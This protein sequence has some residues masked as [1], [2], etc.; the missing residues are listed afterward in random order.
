VY[1]FFVYLSLLHNT[2]NAKQNL[3]FAAQNCGRV[4]RK[5]G[6]AAGSS[7]EKMERS[8]K[9]KR[10]KSFR[11]FVSF[12]IAALG[13]CFMTVCA[14]ANRTNK[15]FDI[16][17]NKRPEWGKNWCAPTA[18]GN[19][20]A[21]LAKEYPGLSG[22]MKDGTGTA[23]SA[24][25]VI[26]DLGKNYMNTDPDKGT[27]GANILK[28]KTDYIKA[29]GDKIT[30]ETK[31]KP[32]EKW[33][34]EQYDKGQDVEIGIGYYEKN[35]AGK[36]V[37]RGHVKTYG[38]IPGEDAGGHVLSLSDIFDSSGSLDDSDFQISFTDPG[39]DDLAGQYGAI[40][41]DQYWLTD[42][43]GVAWWNTESTYNMYWEPDL[44]GL[45]Q[46]GYLLN[47]YQG[48]G[49][50]GRADDP[51]RNEYSIVEIAWAESPVPAPAAIMLGGVGVTLVGWLRKRRT[52]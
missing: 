39:R 17:Q 11:F 24:E 45:G 16:P 37:R 42:Y 48:L 10:R 14:Y 31:V 19:S 9:M 52:L 38:E 35:A 4:A 41:S 15:F 25:E 44:F 8:T 22:L 29:H 26:N 7:N 23:R 20:L 27:T 50:F 1:A 49:D 32:S 13:F 2:K 6:Y 40:A 33:L 51:A 3:I 34:K 5:W 28:G 18:V 47:G 43:A 21:W 12:C 46:G 36:L 30:I